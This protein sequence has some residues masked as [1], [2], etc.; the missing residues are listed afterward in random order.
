MTLKVDRQHRVLEYYQGVLEYY[1]VWSNDDSGLT[2]TYFM[3]MSNFVPYAF[4]WEEDKTKDFSETIVIY[5]IKVGR[6]SQLNEYMKLVSTKD[7]GDSL[8]LVQIAQIQ[9]SFPQ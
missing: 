6:C 5:D 2:M 9:T 1:Q 7:Q 4:V 3:A 8:I